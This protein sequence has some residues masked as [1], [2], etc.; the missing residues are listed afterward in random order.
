MDSEI[1]QLRRVWEADPNDKAAHNAYH[2]A[3][4]RSNQLRHLA[5]FAGVNGHLEALTAVLADIEMRGIPKAICLGD[6]IGPESDSVG[7]VNLLAEKGVD[8]LLGFHEFLLFKAKGFSTTCRVTNDGM[9]S[10]R[11]ELFGDS[12]RIIET[13]DWP[14]IAPI[15]RGE[16]PNKVRKY[17]QF[18]D[19]CS[20]SLLAYKALFQQNSREYIDFDCELFAPSWACD[21]E[22]LRQ[23]GKNCFES[24]EKL[25]FVGFRVDLYLVNERLELQRPTKANNSL[26]IDPKHKTIVGVGCVAHP[27][28][29]H[30]VEVLGNEVIW[31]SVSYEAKVSGTPKVSRFGSK[32][33]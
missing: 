3:L 29:A 21:E 13:D 14:K 26:F 33:P 17:W 6:M 12:L 27:P 25:M 1:A 28:E 18:F 16:I 8:C 24:F 20:E 22:E 4:R 31:R 23:H 5:V 11:K 30:Y 15:T 9:D 2:G 10:V 32:W 19:Q 7:C